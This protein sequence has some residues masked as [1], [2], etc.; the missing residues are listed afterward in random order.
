MKK[1]YESW[2]NVL[3]WLKERGLKGVRMFLVLNRVNVNNTIYIP[4]FYRLFSYW[5]ARKSEYPLFTITKARPNEAALN[6]LQ[7]LNVSFIPTHF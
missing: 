1:D 4:D 5:P 6:T 7:N 3:L 2:K